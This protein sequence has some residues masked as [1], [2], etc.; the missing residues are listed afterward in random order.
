MNN[1]KQIFAGCLILALVVS[2]RSVEA[3]TNLT[4]FSVV[5]NAVPPAMTPGVVK[6]NPKKPAITVTE[7]DQF[8]KNLTGAYESRDLRRF[9][10]FVPQSTVGR[11]RLQDAVRNDF[12]T[13]FNIRIYRQDDKLILGGDKAVYD[14][15]W[16]RKSFLNQNG[17]MTPISDER[18]SQIFLVRGADGGIQ[19][20]MNH[21]PTAGGG[22]GGFPF[23][24][25]YTTAGASVATATSLTVLGQPGNIFLIIVRDPSVNASTV[26]V[27][28]VNNAVASDRERFVIP[29]TAPGVFQRRITLVAAFG[30]V[31]P[32]NGIPEYDFSA[33]ARGTHTFTYSQARDRFGLGGGTKTSVVLLP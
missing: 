12:A 8:L 2:Y 32:F 18:R 15:L 14:S 30:P 11:D 28:Y 16:R 9:M 25:S 23:V 26:T 10:N 27:D 33:G 7:V 21:T 3:Q 1:L 19:M 17:L 6:E 31:T 5:S 4:S 29:M 20:D 22:V 24:S 13:L